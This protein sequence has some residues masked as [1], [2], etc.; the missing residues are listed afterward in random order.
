MSEA[1]K[2]SAKHEEARASLPENLRSVFDGLV[3]DYK[4][5]AA[6]RHGSPWVSYVVL[7]DLVRDG[8]RRS[9]ERTD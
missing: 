4:F 5:A 6:S 3:A 1:Q 9:S 7:A 2:R 8:W